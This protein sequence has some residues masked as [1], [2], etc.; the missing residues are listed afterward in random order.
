MQKR[1]IIKCALL[2]VIVHLAFG[3][4]CFPGV[5]P[6]AQTV[7]AEMTD[8]NNNT[9]N[10]ADYITADG[11]LHIVVFRGMGCVNCIA[12]GIEKASDVAPDFLVVVGYV[13]EKELDWFKKNLPGVTVLRDKN[14]RLIEG[15]R[16]RKTPVMLKLNKDLLIVKK[17]K[18]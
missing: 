5:N 6:K 10:P 17:I 12:A 15:L 8:I 14:Y 9:V 7:P 11:N 16:I 13:F 1:R 4:L 2:L 3:N 18:L